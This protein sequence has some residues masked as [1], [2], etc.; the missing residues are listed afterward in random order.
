[1]G[2]EKLEITRELQRIAVLPYNFCLEAEVQEIRRKYALP[3]DSEEACRLFEL[4]RP[5]WVLSVLNHVMRVRNPKPYTEAPFEPDIIELLRRF[6]LP[7]YVFARL[8]E[9]VLSNDK[10]YLG[11]W[12]LD[13]IVKKVEWDMRTG[14]LRLNVT[15]WGLTPWTTKQQWSSLWDERVKQ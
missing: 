5:T 4:F 12:V 14:L 6:Q 10:I 13:P 7:P 9:Y 8:L 3:A 1:M 2:E 15:I 11:P